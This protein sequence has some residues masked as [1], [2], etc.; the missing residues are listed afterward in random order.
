MKFNLYITTA[1]VTGRIDFL[2]LTRQFVELILTI[3]VID[4]Q[5]VLPSVVSS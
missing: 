3:Q 2:F 1:C 4:C 5:A